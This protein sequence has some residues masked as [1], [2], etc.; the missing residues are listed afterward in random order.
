MRPTRTFLLTVIFITAFIC[1]SAFSEITVEPFG[2]AVS[3]EEDGEVEIELVLSNS[4]E[5][6]VAFS[7]DYEL[8]EAP[9]NRQGGPRRDDLGDIIHEFDVPNGGADEQKVGVAWDWGNDWMWIS[10]N[11]N[12]SVVAVDPNDDYQVTR[13]IDVETPFNVAC[14][15][16]HL[17]IIN[18]AL[19]SIYHYDT[20]G[21]NLGNIDVG[22]NTGAITRSEEMGLLFIMNDATRAIHVFTVQDN[23]EPDEQI[24]VI[25]NLI[26]YCDGADRYRS[27]CWVDLHPNGQLWLSRS[28]VDGQGGDLYEILIDTEEWEPVETVQNCNWW[29][30][31]AANRQRFGIGHDG[32]NIWT[33]AYSLG[34]VRIIDDNIR[35]FHMLT[36]EPENGIIPGEDAETVQILIVTEGCEV[37]T[38]N[39]LIEIALSEPEENR[40]DLEQSLIEISAVVSIGVPTY[41]I[42]GVVTDANENP[43]IEGAAVSPDRYLITTFSDGEGNYSLENLPSGEYRFIFSAPD[44]LPA[45]VDVSIEEEDVELSVALLH[46]EFTPEYD[47]FIRTLEPDQELAIEFNVHNGGN[48]TLTYQ[49][50]SRLLGG[51]DAEPWDLRS[52]YNIEQ[53]VDDDMINGVTFA[54]GHFYVSGGNNGNNPNMIYVF[55]SE[56]E[57]VG[58]FEQVH[59]SRYGMRD[60]TYDGDLIWGA[61]ENVLYGYTTDGDHVETLEGEAQSYRS[62]TWDPLNDRFWSADITSNIFA[63]NREGNLVQT[64]IRPGDIR[65]YGLGF[66]PDDPD[67]HCLY[68]FSRGDEIDIVV[69]KVNLDNGEAVLVTEI[70]AGGSRPGGIH[71]T[72]QLDV[73]SWVLMGIVQTPDRMMVWQLS[74]NSAWFQ[75]APESGEIE[76]DGNQTFV[77]DLNST[78]LPPFNDFNGE[79]VFTHDG[80]GGET[81]IPVTLRVEEGEVRT[82]REL[83]L[84]I[85]WNTVSVN[86]LPDDHENIRVV[87]SALVEEDLLIMMKNGAGEF[88][89]PEYDFSNIRGWFAPQGY[90]LKMRDNVVFRL[91]G[92]SVLQDAE[93]TLSE[94]WQL[95]SYFP[96]SQIEATIALSG[97]EE[98]LIIAKDGHGNFYIPDWDFSN[99]G[100]MCEGQGYYVNVDAGVVLIY[101]F[102]RPDDE[103]AFAGVPHSSVYDEPGQLPVHAV[104]GVNM[105]LLVLAD[106]S[107]TGD[108]GVYTD[109]KLVGS[110]VL[111]DGVCGIAVWGDDPSTSETDGAL[112][113]QPLEIRLLTG[114]GGHS[115]PPPYNS[116]SAVDYALLSGEAIYHTDALS[117]IRLSS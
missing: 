92:I 52:M 65:I 11:P 90:Q 30:N 9:D 105:S 48:G 64:I 57:H 69:Y 39:I 95:I 19:N 36:V 110:G 81:L 16:G 71:I 114:E 10:N 33:T 43:A 7:I 21:E 112:K 77:L 82:F 102:E 79:L 35:E 8:I 42:S 99:M 5:V 29:P 115:C 12:S 1:N 13:E 107:L 86:L 25:P 113:G 54:E 15:Y 51:A 60:L 106:Q 63:T 6:D 31:A 37:G 3:V 72:N 68:V 23:G 53:I 91:D 75:I 101:R 103:G 98:H 56:G 45:V 117:V 111:Q 58:N 26:D 97:I 55:D 78:D 38:Y 66:W 4:D 83:D 84:N 104:T 67:G 93:I 70:D 41:S 14:L 89:I 40:D 2:F 46:S 62:L 109:S 22:F 34:V 49:V 17:Y 88:Y 20:G 28:N 80:V 73:Y 94:G 96:H 24:G 85:G 18:N 61:D 47:G 32:E 74:T 87:M 59:E 44:Y 76:A 108:V 116:E 50:D 100:E 27:I